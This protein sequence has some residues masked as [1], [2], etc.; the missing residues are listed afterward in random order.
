MNRA[1]LRYW[2]PFHLYLPLGAVLLIGAAVGAPFSWITGGL[3]FTLGV[4][5]WPLLEYGVHRGLFHLPTRSTG[6]LSSLSRAHLMHHDD[7]QNIEFIF[8]RLYASAPITTLMFLLLWAG[9]GQWQKAVLAIMG[10]WAGYMFYEFVHY[11]AHF[12][13]PQTALM[14]YLKKYH[15]LHHHQDDQTRFGVTTPV[16]DWLLGTYRPIPTQSIVHS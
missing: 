6:V 4:V 11:S 7:P 15:M 3:I 16:I 1:H 5:S 2:R 10:Q 12:R 14:R 13:A 9:L 8:V